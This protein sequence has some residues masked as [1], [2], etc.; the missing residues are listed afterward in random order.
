MRIVPS[1]CPCRPTCSADLMSRSTSPGVR[2]SRLLRSALVGFRG[3]L[4]ELSR[5]RVLARGESVAKI[6]FESSLSSSRL[7]RKWTF[8]GMFPVVGLGALAVL[9]SVVVIVILSLPSP[10]A[11]GRSRFGYSLRELGRQFPE[12]VSLSKPLGKLLVDNFSESHSLGFGFR[13]DLSFCG[14]FNADEDLFLEGW[15][16]TGTLALSSVLTLSAH[17][18]GKI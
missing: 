17:V 2:Y 12:G 6:P 5:K 9:D 16:S 1:R 10:V 7:S 3:G 18:I 15:L 13:A 4:F 11:T 8:S 14:R